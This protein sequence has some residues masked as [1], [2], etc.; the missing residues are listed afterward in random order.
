MRYQY[1]D[2]TCQTARTNSISFYIII[3]DFRFR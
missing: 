2:H 1:F 3:Y